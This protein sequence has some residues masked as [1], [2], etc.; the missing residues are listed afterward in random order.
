V[1]NCHRIACVASISVGLSA[2]LKHFSLCERAKIGASAKK[3]EKL[4]GN[5]E[6]PIPKSLSLFPICSSEKH[7]TAYS[8][9]WKSKEIIGIP[10]VVPLTMSCF[11]SVFL[12][13][14]IIAKKGMNWSL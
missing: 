4:S 11:L 2:G 12:S 9:C 10:S 14:K 6:F 13:G 8:A 3:C 7:F 5:V 1:H